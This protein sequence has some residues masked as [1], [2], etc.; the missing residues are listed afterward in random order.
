MDNSKN[1]FSSFCLYLYRYLLYL[2][3][4]EFNFFCHAFWR[5]DQGKDSIKMKK[6]FKKKSGSIFVCE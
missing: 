2:R 5:W 4:L 1:R 6:N 3:T